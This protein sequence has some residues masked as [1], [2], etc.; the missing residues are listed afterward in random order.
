MYEE[1][2]SLLPPATRALI[3]DSLRN[4]SL[5]DSYRAGGVDGDN[6]WPAYSNPA[7]MRALATGWTGRITN[8]SNMTAAGERYAAEVLALFDRNG[9]LSEFNSP[10]Y[11]G[12]S[13]YALTLWAKYL[14]ADGNG[15]G[16]GSSSVMARRA[17]GMIAD[18]WTTV[19]ALYHAGLRNLAGPWDRSY[20]YDQNLY[21]GIM[22]IYFWSLVGAARAPGINNNNNA[23]GGSGGGGG[24]RLPYWATTHADDF[25]IAPLLAAVLPYHHALVPDAARAALVAFPGEHAYAT[26]AYAPPYDLVP[27]N[28]TAWLGEALTIGA[29]SFDQTAVGG[30]SLNQE[31]WNPAVAQWARGD[32][33]VGWLTWY[34]TESAV[35]AE[36]Q[37]G[38]LGLE[39]PRGNASSVFTFLVASNPLGQKRDIRGWGD[40][41]GLSV[42]VSGT[43]DP[44]PEISF[45][46]LLGGACDP[47]NEFEF[48]NFTYLMPAGSTETPSIVLDMAVV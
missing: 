37:G 24:H 7:L 39:Y 14:P 44:T 3:V 10:T 5:G 9:T 27:R 6:L 29:E 23:L 13:L 15:T 45:C 8:D 38:R 43:V 2:G 35:D 47:I 33:S 28:V 18:I 11:C 41:M 16:S 32:G 42:N 26:A 34:A 4:E 17:P 22:N 36:V 48:W 30:F 1:Y 12:V 31:A 46:G 19:G 20:G 25:E 21:V 40:V